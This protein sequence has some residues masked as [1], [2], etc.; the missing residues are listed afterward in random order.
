MSQSWRSSTTE[1][2]SKVVQP[3]PVA[4]DP[5]VALIRLCLRLTQP[6]RAAR[7]GEIPDRLAALA[8]DLPDPVIAERRQQ[9]AIKRQAALD[10]RDDQVDVVD[11]ARAH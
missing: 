6:D 8:L 5:V 4:V 10:R 11:A 3:D 7:A 9:L 2:E 1:L